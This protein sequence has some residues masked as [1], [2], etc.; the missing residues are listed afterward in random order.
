[1]ELADGVTGWA[2]TCLVFTGSFT[3]LAT[4]QRSDFH[5]LEMDHGQSEEISSRHKYPK[6]LSHRSYA[7]VCHDSSTTHPKRQNRQTAAQ[8]NSTRRTRAPPITNPFSHATTP[9]TATRAPHSFAKPPSLY[10]VSTRLASLHTT[11]VTTLL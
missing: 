7:H 3:G 11:P 1:M 2:F 4:L 5:G 9:A 8:R 10:R 6:P